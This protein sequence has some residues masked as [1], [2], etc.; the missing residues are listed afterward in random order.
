MRCSR[1]NGSRNQGKNSQMV[2][3]GYATR[4]EFSARK[5]FCRRCGKDHPRTSC[6]GY[7]IVCY[8]CGRLGHQAAECCR[9]PNVATSQQL[10]Q[11]GQSQN[12]SASQV[13]NLGNRVGGGPSPASG[14]SG[15]PSGSNQGRGEGSQVHNGGNES[16][17]IL[18]MS[19]SQASVSNL[20]LG[21]TASE[22][23]YS[24]TEGRP[25]LTTAA[26][27]DPHCRYMLTTRGK[28]AAMRSEN[29]G[30]GVQLRPY[31]GLAILRLRRGRKP[32]LNEGSSLE[33]GRKE[34]P[35]LPAE[36]PLLV[37]H[38]RRRWSLRTATPCFWSGPLR[39]AISTAFLHCRRSACR[40]ERGRREI[41]EKKRRP[42][43]MT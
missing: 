6:L 31:H 36:P 29:V 1:E 2:G 38:G 40:E 42:R 37:T 15:Q 4:R 41:E 12:G 24:H 16:R 11:N 26:E 3:Q 25:P 33:Q 7:P 32:A 28:D 30:G 27:K 39:R 5:T 17:R 19:Q 8:S 9:Q 22:L 23:R 21:Y 18:V 14:S 34:T 10:N 43:E 35:P 20:E 13:N